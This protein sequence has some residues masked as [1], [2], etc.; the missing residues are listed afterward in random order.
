M[1]LTGIPPE[2]I[3]YANPIKQI[4]YIQYAAEMGVELMTFDCEAEL[5]KVKKCY[6]S[7]K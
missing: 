2:R 5:L 3:V 6:P 7:A 1:E 4:S